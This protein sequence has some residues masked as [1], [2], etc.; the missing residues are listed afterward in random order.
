MGS[1]F[2]AYSTIYTHNLVYTTK[3]GDNSGS[4]SGQVSFDSNFGSA[5]DFLGGGFNTVAINRSLITNVTFTYTPA[6]G[7]PLTLTSND[8][9][10]FRLD[11]KNNG[12]TD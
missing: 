12:A 10:M 1:C 11:H 7:N 3:P 9:T 8:I 5:N 6:G 4:L 2:P